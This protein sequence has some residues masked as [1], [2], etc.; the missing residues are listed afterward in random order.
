[1]RDGLHSLLA[2]FIETGEMDRLAGRVRSSSDEDLE[3]VSHYAT[4][5]AAKRLE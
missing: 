4:A 5:P 2:L 3:K 1:V